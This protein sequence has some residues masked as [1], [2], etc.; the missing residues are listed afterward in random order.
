MKAVYFI[1]RKKKPI[2]SM[3][4]NKLFSLL[5]IFLTLCVGEEQD[6]RNLRILKLVPLLISAVFLDE[7]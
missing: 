6:L 4:K 5:V 2:I 7:C 3:V 1:P